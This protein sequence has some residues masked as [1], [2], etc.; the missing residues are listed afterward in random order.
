DPTWNPASGN[1]IAL[2]REGGGGSSQ[3]VGFVGETDEDQ[4]P[5]RP[6]GA[7]FGDRE[8]VG[9]TAVVAH[10][11]EDR[12]TAVVRRLLERKLGILAQDRP[13]EVAQER[14]PVAPQRA[15]EGDGGAA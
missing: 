14:R 12:P 1:C 15:G 5:P 4:P 8:Q 2:L 11:D 10:E 3:L 13:L 7:R 9:K 6:G